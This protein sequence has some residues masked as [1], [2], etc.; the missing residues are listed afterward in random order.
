VKK[1]RPPGFFMTVFDSRSQRTAAVPASPP[2]GAR[3]EEIEAVYRSRLGTFVRVWTAMLGNRELAIDA[4][5]DGFAA[6]I[7]RR[8]SFRRDGSVEGGCGRSS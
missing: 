8:E 6:A 1:R 4:V 7:R 3:I 2:R 5:H